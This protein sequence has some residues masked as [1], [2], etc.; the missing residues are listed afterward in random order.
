M[1]IYQVR[2]ITNQIIIKETL[3]QV[4]NRNLCQ[5]Y[6]KNCNGGEIIGTKLSNQS[7]SVIYLD[8][9]LKKVIVMEEVKT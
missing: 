4:T 2:R 1:L 9:S 5:I 3:L 6:Q 8:Q 7:R